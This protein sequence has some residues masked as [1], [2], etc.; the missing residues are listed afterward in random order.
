MEAL[1]ALAEIET[2]VGTVLLATVV[3]VLHV[4]DY[5]EP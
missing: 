5:C 4:A 3:M 1:G 2:T